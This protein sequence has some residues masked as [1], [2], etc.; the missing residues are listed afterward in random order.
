MKTTHAVRRTTLLTAALLLVLVSVASI[1][2]AVYAQT[3]GGYDLTWSTV[4]GGGG[5]ST[6]GSYTLG[7]TAGQPDAGTM[8]GGGYTLSNGFWGGA[9]TQ[10]RIYLPLTLKSY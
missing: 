7:G 2:S 6:G 4:D 3:G 1:A 8:T 10:Y 9:A 5:V